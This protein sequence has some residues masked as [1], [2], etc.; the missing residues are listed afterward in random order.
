MKF[1]RTVAGLMTS[2]YFFATMTGCASHHAAT[3]RAKVEA[4]PAAQIR[5]TARLAGQLQPAQPLELEGYA[6]S[7][8][9]RYNR[10]YAD[11]SSYNTEPNAFML[12][13]LERIEA[14]HD[15]EAEPKTVEAQPQ[16]TALDIAMG[17]GR[18]AIALAQRGY[19]ASGFDMS[20]VGVTRARQGAVDVGVDID[21]RVC[22]F[23]DY[24]FGAAQ[25]DVVVMMYFSVDANDMKR[26]QDSVKPGGYMIIERSGGDVYNEFPQQFKEWEIIHYE[27]DWGPR[28]WASAIG[29]APPGPR[30]QFLA[31]KRIMKPA[32]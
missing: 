7:Q 16:R 5:A 28:D 21:A 25:W 12:A 22:F 13:C 20:D 29:N 9:D 8:R 30:T 1:T 26:I 19:R 31:K 11:P 15:R 10:T 17:D 24:N 14:H 3:S 4:N 2:A 18:N 32:Y 27:Q 6:R 23:R